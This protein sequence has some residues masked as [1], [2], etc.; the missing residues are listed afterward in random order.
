MEQIGDYIAR[1]NPRRAVT[2][3]AELRGR[4]EA[5]LATPEGYPIVPEYGSNI[6][7]IV[8]GN[9]NIYYRVV[10]D[11]IVLKTVRHSARRVVRIR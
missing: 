7:R 11:Q 4:C 2:F 6:R 10:G 1:D 3:I 9:Y 5:L 8:H